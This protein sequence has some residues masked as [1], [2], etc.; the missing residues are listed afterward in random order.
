MSRRRASARSRRA[1]SS[2]PLR[3]AAPAAI[4]IVGVGIMTS[5]GSARIAISATSSSRGGDADQQVQRGG[6]QRRE[7]EQDGD[8]EHGRDR[9]DR[10]PS[11]RTCRRHSHRDGR[12]GGV[13]TAESRDRR[14]PAMTCATYRSCARS[15]RAAAGPRW[16]DP[17]RAV[18]IGPTMLSRRPRAAWSAGH[19][20]RD[21]WCAGRQRV[22]RAARRVRPASS[23]RRDE[24]RGCNAAVR[25]ARL[26]A[27]AVRAR[28]ARRCAPASSSA[29]AT[30]SRQTRRRILAC[31]GSDPVERAVA[32]AR[33]RRPGR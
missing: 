11:E 18:A 6:R 2:A 3:G 16:C 33:R 21:R 13:S 19:R 5:V 17:R 20:A 30:A 25:F 31:T 12:T 10:R 22:P 24:H 4:G 29:P 9:R 26:R 15:A 32:R 14:R 27:T 1:R 7:S 28:R 8:Q 23:V